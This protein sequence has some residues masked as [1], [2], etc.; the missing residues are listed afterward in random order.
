MGSWGNLTAT[1]ASI[2]F[3]PTAKHLHHTRF[4]TVV[5]D[6]EKLKILAQTVCFL[7]LTKTILSD[8]LQDEKLLDDKSRVL[9]E[10]GSFLNIYTF[11]PLSNTIHK[12]TTLYAQKTLPHSFNPYPTGFPYGNGMVL[13]FYQQ[14][15]S[16]T[17]KTVH[18]VINKGLKAYV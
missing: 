11:I 13:H 7:Y 2:S 6:C 18:K 3:Y 4:H 16:S 15:E 8:F 9:A 5:C 10:K 17:T 1:I 12:T 14:Q